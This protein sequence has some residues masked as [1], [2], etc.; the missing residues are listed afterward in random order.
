VLVQKLFRPFL[1]ARKFVHVLKLKNA[2]QWRKYSRSDKRPEDIPSTPS[3]TY[4]NN[5]WKSWGDWLGT[6]STATKNRKFRTFEDARKFI[7]SLGLK[8]YTD[9]NAYCISGNKPDDIPSAPWNTYKN[10]GWISTGHWLGTGRVADQLKQYRP[11]S[12]ARAFV[13]SLGFK[14][15]KEWFEYCKSVNKPDDIPTAAQKTY[16][17]D[18]K[19]WG[20][21]LGTGKISNVEKSKMF[22][23][24]KEAQEFVHSL[25]FIG[26]N[27][28]NKYCTS[29]KKPDDIPANPNTTYKNKGWI[30]W[31]D[32]L[33]TGTI[34]TYNKIYRP[35]PEA[36]KFVKTLGIKNRQ[37]WKE[38]C[39]SGKKPDD[40]PSQPWLV[41]SKENVFRRM[42]RH[43]KEI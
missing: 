28:W 1:E 37:D 32:W 42:K 12:D 16:K 31:G 40:I 25:K 30:R 11:F 2:D 34:A 10:S 33:G 6:V 14:G 18:W 5:G 7:L 22:R 24:Y 26:Q 21:W 41:Y 4:K 43:E 8:S 36:K 20:D 27:D 29:D 9:W 19:S 15:Q 38:Y 13:N 3:V 23:P 39:K 17:K 35:F